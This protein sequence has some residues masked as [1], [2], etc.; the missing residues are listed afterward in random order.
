MTWSQHFP[1]N[2]PPQTAIDL[3]EPIYRLISGNIPKNR[4]FKSY[5]LQYPDRNWGEKA[6]QACGL[7][8]HTSLED[9]LE[10]YN[11]LKRR[12]PSMRKKIAVAKGNDTMGKILNTPSKEDLTHHTCLVASS[13]TRQTL[14]I[15]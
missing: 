8:V 6:C 9:C 5:W 11:R 3:N 10:N 1:Q 15:V 14:G 4:D 12:I 13:G 7:S 2:C